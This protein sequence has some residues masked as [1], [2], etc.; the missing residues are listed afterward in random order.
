[1]ASPAKL[2]SCAVQ[3]MASAFASTSCGMCS[4]RPAVMKTI[5][6]ALR[7][8]PA[9]ALH[10]PALDLGQPRLRQRRRFPAPVVRFAEK[11][12]HVRRLAGQRRRVRRLARRCRRRAPVPAVEVVVAAARVSGL[13]PVRPDPRE[14]RRHPLQ[15]LVAVARIG[16]EP[17]LRLLVRQ[18]PEHAQADL[19]GRRRDRQQARVR[20]GRPQQHHRGPRQ[21]A[22]GGRG[23]GQQRLLAVGGGFRQR[24]VE[25]ADALLAL[26]HLGRPHQQLVLADAPLLHQL[27]QVAQV[28]QRAEVEVDAAL[29]EGAVRRLLRTAGV[30]EAAVE[31]VDRVVVRFD[32]GAGPGVGPDQVAQERVGM[33]R[34]AV[35]RH[36]AHHHPLR[37]GLESACVARQHGLQELAALDRQ[38]GVVGTGGVL[39]RPDVLEDHRDAAGRGQALGAGARHLAHEARAGNHAAFL[40]PPLVLGEGIVAGE[41]DQRHAGV[42]GVDRRLLVRPPHQRHVEAVERERRDEIDSPPPVVLQQDRRMT[43]RARDLLQ[44]A[45]TRARPVRC[46]RSRRAPPRARY[47]RRS[48]AGTARDRSRSAGRPAAAGSSRRPAPRRARRCACGL[49]SADRVAIATPAQKYIIW[50]TLSSHWIYQS[51]TGRTARIRS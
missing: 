25:Q 48:A 43:V 10:Q 32:D 42:L 12:H 24:G 44:L 38:G 26:Q 4:A 51:L 28:E 19:V 14:R 23:A 31:L 18:R 46:R 22:V 29:A 39:V 45:Q 21:L 6:F 50:L 34:H 7:I 30:A 49:L 37:P 41:P 13:R 8:G 3:K 16:A 35:Q 9:H 20:P 17:V 1:M 11:Q 40:G 5:S 33:C 47:P 2:P 27:R 15:M 36:E